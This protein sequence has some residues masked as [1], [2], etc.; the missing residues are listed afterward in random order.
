VALPPAVDDPVLLEPPE[1]EVLPD[2][3]PFRFCIVPFTSTRLPTSVAK[4][5][6]LPVSR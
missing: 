6:A 1:V 4:F 2:P 5:E 3:E